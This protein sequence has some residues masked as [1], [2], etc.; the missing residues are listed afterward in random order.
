MVASR[1]AH[2]NIGVHRPQE[3]WGFMALERGAL[4]PKSLYAPL[5]SSRLGRVR[6]QDPLEWGLGTGPCAGP[7]GA[8]TGDGPCIKPSPTSLPPS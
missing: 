3:V 8:G 1:G 6:A 5:S 4:F 7:P 2:H